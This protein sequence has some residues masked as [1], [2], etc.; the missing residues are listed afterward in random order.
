MIWI[1]LLIQISHLTPELCILGE[2]DAV[3]GMNLN[4]SHG[5]VVD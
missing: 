2:V 5:D 4:L 3:L 1:M